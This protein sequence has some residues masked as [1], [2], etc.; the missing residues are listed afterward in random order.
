MFIHDDDFTVVEAFRTRLPDIYSAY[1]LGPQDDPE[2]WALRAYTLRRGAEPVGLFLHLV[3]DR[4]EWNQPQKQDWSQGE[5]DRLGNEVAT[6]MLTREE[7]IEEMKRLRGEILP[8]GHEVLGMGIDHREKGLLSWQKIG[9][10]DLE[11]WLSDLRAGRCGELPEFLSPAQA[12]KLFG[13]P[14]LAQAVKNEKPT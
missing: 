2:I 6:T 9:T 13:V 1:D 8:G 11:H 14:S 10:E 12:T 4:H 7:L 5:R 3:A